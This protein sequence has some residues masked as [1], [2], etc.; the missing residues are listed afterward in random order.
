MLYQYDRA[1]ETFDRKYTLYQMKMT[2][3]VAIVTIATD[4]QVDLSAR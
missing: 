2:G 4:V 3:G 1:V